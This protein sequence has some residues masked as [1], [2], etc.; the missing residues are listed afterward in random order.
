[1]V[2]GV[3]IAFALVHGTIL[4]VG[5]CFAVSFGCS[6][7]GF[8]CLVLCVCFGWL[9]SVFL[10]LELCCDSGVVLLLSLVESFERFLNYRKKKNID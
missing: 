2:V 1:M 3:A 5:D 6:S 8:G 10:S 4:S 9:F 7:L